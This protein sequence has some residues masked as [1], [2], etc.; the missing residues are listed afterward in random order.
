MEHRESKGL[1]QS[2]QVR[3]QY[4]NPIIVI[5]LLSVEGFLLLKMFQL[6]SL[7]SPSYTHQYSQTCL[8]DTP[9]LSFCLYNFI[10]LDIPFSHLSLCQ[11]CLQVPTQVLF[12]ANP[13]ELEKNQFIIPLKYYCKIYHIRYESTKQLTLKNHLCNH[14]PSE[15]TRPF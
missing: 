8:F 5:N 14:Y 1:I 6:N 15:E 11:F 2:C 10:S 9:L 3:Y 7:T 4:L 13:P 12:Y